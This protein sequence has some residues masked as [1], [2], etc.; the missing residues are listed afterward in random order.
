MIPRESDTMP[1]SVL[2]KLRASPLRV[3]RALRVMEVVGGVWMVAALVGM[4]LSEQLPV[5]RPFV[6]WSFRLAV[7]VFVAFIASAVFVSFVLGVRNVWRLYSD[8]MAI[9]RPGIFGQ[10]AWAMA[11]AVAFVISLWFVRW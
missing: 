4:F 7:G 6:M 3:E 1:D 2:A 10:I 5:L 8:M 11:F 9:V